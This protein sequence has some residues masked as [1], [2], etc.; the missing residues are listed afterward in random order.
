VAGSLAENAV[1]NLRGLEHYLRRIARYKVGITAQHQN[2]F[3]LLVE[4]FNLVAALCELP[5]VGHYF[6]AST[7]LKHQKGHAE[8]RLTRCG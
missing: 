1:R 2:G 6:G 4:N 5:T 7:G 8:R 3:L